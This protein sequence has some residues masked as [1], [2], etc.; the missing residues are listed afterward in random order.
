MMLEPVQ[1]LGKSLLKGIL[2]IIILVDKLDIG[3]VQVFK[4]ALSGRNANFFF[5]TS[6]IEFRFCL[7]A[8]MNADGITLSDNLVSI[9]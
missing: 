9:D 7:V 5:Y 3:R 6:A 2:S 4:Y 8:E 1:T